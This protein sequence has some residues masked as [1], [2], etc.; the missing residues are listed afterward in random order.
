M[1]MLALLS[2]HIKYK[3]NEPVMEFE[4]I[5]GFWLDMQND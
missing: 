1:E 2:S 3:L 5:K 4:A